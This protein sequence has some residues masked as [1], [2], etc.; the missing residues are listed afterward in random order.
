MKPLVVLVALGAFAGVGGCASYLAYAH[1][2]LYP[3]AVAAAHS[4]LDARAA[5][6]PEDPLYQGLRGVALSGLELEGV[7]AMKLRGQLAYGAGVNGEAVLALVRAGERWRVT[8]CDL[9]CPALY[10]RL[11]AD[12]HHTAAAFLEALRGGDWTTLACT[13]DLDLVKRMGE[14][15][16]RG[17]QRDFN[18]TIDEARVSTSPAR[19]E[20][21]RWTFRGSA[22]ATEGPPLDV[23]LTVRWRRGTLGVTDFRFEPAAAWLAEQRNVARQVALNFVAAMKAGEVADMMRA[24]HPQL[25][26]TLTPARFEAMA[27][28]FAAKLSD[29]TFDE[30]KTVAHHP[31]YDLTGEQRTNEGARLPA[32]VRV[33]YVDGRYL[34]TA[35]RF[36]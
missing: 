32:S 28:D 23:E 27:Q 22:R 34:I 17:I 6:R 1:L 26:E 29:I 13:L 14:E 36:D 15:K 24:C 5:A 18:R 4:E 19:E 35:L 9:D 3:G 21:S 33:Q 20:P 25:V 8:A 11:R 31:L 7:S 2:A 10:E 12:A 16:I 30:A